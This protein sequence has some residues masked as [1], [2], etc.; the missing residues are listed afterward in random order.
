MNANQSFGMFV[1]ILVWTLL[2]FSIGFWW[3][4]IGEQEDCNIVQQLPDCICEVKECPTTN[5]VQEIYDK[6]KDVEDMRSIL[7][8]KED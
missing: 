8:E 6:Q 5:C 7:N 2:V 4:A 1:A 3:S